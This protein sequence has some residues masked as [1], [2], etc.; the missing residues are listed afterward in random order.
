VLG[1]EAVPDKAGEV[2]AIPVLPARLAENNGLRGALVSIDAIATDATIATAIQDAGADYLL[3]VKAN[4]P[5]L[6]AEVEACF[7]TAPPRPARA[8]STP[9]TTRA[10]A[11]S[12]SAP[13]A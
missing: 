11:A 9:T 12:N 10:M 1:R 3:A 2:A 4:Q 5:T 8:P 13:R 7:A 6:R